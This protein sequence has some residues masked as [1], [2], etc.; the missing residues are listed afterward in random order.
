MGL[1]DRLN[2]ARSYLKSPFTLTMLERGSDARVHVGA[3]ARVV[4]EVEGED[5]GSVERIELTLRRPDAG[6][7]SGG[8][9]ETALGT[10]PRTVGRHELTVTIPPG[11]LPSAVGFGSY[12]F[13]GRVVRS[14]GVESEALSPVVVVGREEDL[15]WPDGPRI[16]TAGPPNVRLDVSVDTA[17]AVVGGVVTGR[18]TVQALADLPAAAV[19]VQVGPEI[20]ALVKSLTSTTLERRTKFKASA[21]QTLAPSAALSAGQRLEVPFTLAVSPGLPPTLRDGESSVVWQVRARR[22]DAGGWATIGVLDPK[23][24]SAPAPE[25]AQSLLDLLT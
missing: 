24:L 3:P 16:G 14:K 9:A 13:R 25:R 7:P 1:K 8:Y 5:D 22:G 18:V 17:T 23:S 21:S 6:N 15:Y 10:V 4:V 2:A 11:T 19:E 20:N 12:V